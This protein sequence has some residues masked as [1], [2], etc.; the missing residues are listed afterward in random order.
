MV[1]VAKH[2]D[3]DSSISDACSISDVCVILYA[4]I[5][6]HVCLTG[7]ACLRSPADF[8][9]HDQYMKIIQSQTLAY[10]LMIA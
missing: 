7:H 9:H 10:I 5:L 2:L 8:I 1:G 4:W 3:N 6:C